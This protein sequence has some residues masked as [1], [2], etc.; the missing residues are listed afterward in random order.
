MKI[1]YITPCECNI[2]T[3]SGTYF[4]IAKSLIDRGNSID[5]INC[6]VESFSAK[7]FQWF[8]KHIIM[9][10]WPISCNEVLMKKYSK[11]AQSLIKSDSDLVFS[12]GTLHIPNLEPKQKLII[13]SDATFQAMLDFY[14][15]YKKMHP[16]AIK[17]GI[18]MEKQVF[19]RATLL[20]FASDWAANSAIEHYGIDSQKVKVIPF[21]AN[22]NLSRNKVDILELLKNKKWDK[23][24]LLFVGVEWER[25]NAQ[26]VVEIVKKL[27]EIVPTQL[28]LVG[29]NNIPLN[30]IPE[31]IVNHGFVSKSTEHGQAYLRQLFEQSHFLLVPS[32]AEAY[33]LVFCEAN[34]FGLPAISSNVGGIPTIIKDNINGIKFP[35]SASPKEYVD[36]ILDL[37][38]EREKYYKLAL[39]S[40]KEYETRLNW[41]TA[42]KK[43]NELVNK[44]IVLE[45]PSYR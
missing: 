38:Y 32:K 34:A 6:K 45:V 30:P 36:W 7:F 44:V 20:I 13:Y 19:D 12:P 35:L 27:N 15:D 42:S 8:F 23:L 16:K 43:I 40:F 24:K 3:W 9:L 11:K 14:D 37:Y 31:F 41:E 26:M 5:Y 39:S 1:A 33:G 10:G 17:N 21:G 22:I 18:K 25:K 4:F 28:D 29:I 2:H